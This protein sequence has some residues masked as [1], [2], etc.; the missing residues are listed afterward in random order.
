[1]KKF[2]SKN[3]IWILFA[4]VIIA[5]MLCVLSAFSSGSSALSNVAGVVTYPFRAG[6]SAVTGW[7]SGISE[8]FSQVDALQ[9]ENEALKKQIAEMEED[10]L[11]SKADSEE[12]Q[13]LRTLLNLRQQRHDFSYESATII[14]RSASNWASILTLGKGTEQDVALNDCVI[15]AEGYLVGVVTQVGLN[16]CTVTTVVDP[17]SQLGALVFRTNEVGVASGDLSLLSTGQLRLNYLSNQQTLINGD[18][19]VTS[20][21]GGY[22]PSG[23]VIG[24]VGEVKTDDS[25]L[26][27]YAI[28]DPKVDLSSLTEVFIITHFDVVK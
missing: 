13:R 12:N 15:N 5:V 24:S 21:L 9:Q 8:R 16:W 18:L 25:G 26:S 3:G 7:V 6:A 27:Q 20:G 11:Q 22:Y 2:F 19:I 4:T 28:I 14:E 23:L 1:M 10:I 17:S